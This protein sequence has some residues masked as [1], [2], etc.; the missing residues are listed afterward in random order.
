MD[1]WSRHP[2]KSWV[3]NPKK[4]SIAFL[5]GFGFDPLFFSMASHGQ[6][7]AHGPKTTLKLLVH[8]QA[9]TPTYGSKSCFRNE[10]AN[11]P[12]SIQNLI[13]QNSF[14]FKQKMRNFTSLLPR[15]IWRKTIPAESPG[16]GSTYEL[17]E[18][19]L[20]S[21]N[22]HLYHTSIFYKGPLLISAHSSIK[23]SLSWFVCYRSKHIQQNETQ[24][25][26]MPGGNS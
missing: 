7:C 25:S 10:K 6:Y 23:E 20:T 8:V 9:I 26:I 11:P 4:C 1:F 3:Q 2:E 14:I 22:N 5:L 24:V 13:A 18:N 17:C 16:P 21:Y 15:S 12:L 19:L